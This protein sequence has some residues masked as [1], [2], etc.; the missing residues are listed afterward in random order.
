MDA[1]SPLRF[2]KISISKNEVKFRNLHSAFTIDVFFENIVTNCTSTKD[3][4]GLW[5]NKNRNVEILI[6]NY[7]TL[8]FRENFFSGLSRLIIPTS[9]ENALC[10]AEALERVVLL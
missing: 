2:L 8:S 1:T 7:L 10:F 9:A 5:Y 4:L 3:Y 6:L